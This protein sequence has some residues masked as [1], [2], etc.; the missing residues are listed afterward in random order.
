[1]PFIDTLLAFFRRVGRP[2]L[3]PPP[4]GLE[5]SNETSALRDRLERALPELTQWPFLYAL[6]ND[7]FAVHLR[8]DVSQGVPGVP[9]DRD[10]A[11]MAYGVIFRRDADSYTLLER[12]GGEATK[13]SA[14]REPL[15]AWLHKSAQRRLPGSLTHDADYTP[16]AARAATQPAVE[17]PPSLYTVG[18]LSGLSATSLGQRVGPLPADYVAFV[19]RWGAAS[20]NGFVRVYAP[21]QVRRD[22]EASRRAHE[23]YFFWDASADLLDKGDYV[24]CVELADTFD[25]DVFASIPANPE[26]VFF[27]PRGGEQA[28]VFSG[29][30][31]AVEA[32][33]RR[34][35]LGTE[36][37][38]YLDQRGGSRQ[39]IAG[40]IRRSARTGTCSNGVRSK[41]GQPVGCR[42]DLCRLSGVL[43]Q[44]AQAATWR[45][46]GARSR[47]RAGLE[48]GAGTT[49]AGLSA[50]RGS[51]LEEH[52]AHRQR[53]QVERVAGEARAVLR[54]AGS[55]RVQQRQEVVG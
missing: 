18:P 46:G 48:R 19:E 28:E 14:L 4:P 34:R 26:W 24:E 15:M 22:L 7:D 50:W 27:F 10:H 2:S 41:A 25:G 6:E 3:A 36:G 38:M 12:I 53:A 51:P 39:G 45:K 29:F 5:W 32:V 8:W 40:P 49:C 1:M 47:H 9:V 17:L 52:V 13:W 21:E 43:G 23:L 55:V 20:V 35:A 31:T 11:P 54:V 42:H 16:V 37:L 30:W 33:V 44:A